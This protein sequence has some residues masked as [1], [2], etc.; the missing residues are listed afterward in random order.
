MAAKDEQR[1]L[2][3]QATPGMVIARPVLSQQHVLLCGAGHVLDEDFITKLMVRGIKRVYVKGH[4]LPSP[5]HAALQEAVQQ[6]RRRFSRVQGVYVMNM[7][8]RLI[9]AQ[10][11]RRYK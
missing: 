7:L 1:I 10:I 9:E 2:L 4:P 3:T 6:L 8:E 5:D 11:I